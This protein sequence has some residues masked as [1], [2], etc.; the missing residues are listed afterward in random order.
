[1]RSEWDRESADENGSSSNRSRLVSVAK[2]LRF[3]CVLHPGPLPCCSPLVTL[4]RGYDEFALLPG[5]PFGAMIPPRVAR[6]AERAT[7]LREAAAALLD[8]AS[9]VEGI[10]ES[11]AAAADWGALLQRATARAPVVMAAGCR[12]GD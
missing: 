1:M 3:P 7:R 9:M 6:G 4:T 11:Q 5:A 10:P 12:G 2:L 8:V